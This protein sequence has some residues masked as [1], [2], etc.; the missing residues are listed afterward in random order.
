MKLSDEIANALTALTK[1]GKAIEQLKADID[2]FHMSADQLQEAKVK[3]SLLRKQKPLFFQSQKINN[4]II[5][6]EKDYNEKAKV[7]KEQH[8]KLLKNTLFEN[9]DRAIVNLNRNFNHQYHKM[10]GKSAEEVHRANFLE[11]YLNSA[12]QDD[13]SKGHTLK[14]LTDDLCNLRTDLAK[15]HSETLLETMT[16]HVYVK[17]DLTVGKSEELTAGENQ[18]TVTGFGNYYASLFNAINP[19]IRREPSIIQDKKEEKPNTASESI[20][21]TEIVL[22]GGFDQTTTLL[23]DSKSFRKRATEQSAEEE[24]IKKVLDVIDDQRQNFSMDGATAYQMAQ[25][26][27]DF[28]VKI[29]R[30]RKELNELEQKEQ[31]TENLKHSL[32]TDQSAA[33]LMSTAFASLLVLDA[34]VI[35]GSYA[36]IGIK[37]IKGSDAT[38]ANKILDFEGP[39]LTSLNLTALQLT[40]IIAAAAF[41]VFYGAYRYTQSKA[42]ALAQQDPSPKLLDSKGANSSTS[43]SRK[44]ANDNQEKTPLLKSS[45]SSELVSEEKHRK[46]EDLDRS[47]QSPQT[48]SKGNNEKQDYVVLSSVD[49]ES[50]G[51]ALAGDS[52]FSRS[53]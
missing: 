25:K 31:T 53:K 29:E 27:I 1:N 11:Q 16:T 3:I 2:M 48:A 52:S 13:K 17:R 41:I 30:G 20:K 28:Q 21:I 18:T 47:L 14:L 15:I 5:K 36:A 19:P 24:N 45:D 37:A 44:T 40:A 32:A 6:A 9:L 38:L 8:Q 49:E 10:T 46:L 26:E 4:D 39:K 33:K 50:L 34:G 51:S 42:N 22:T 23:Q 12:T 35:G 7:Y 43:K